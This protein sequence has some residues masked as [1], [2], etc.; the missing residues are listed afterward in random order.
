MISIF[1]RK[2]GDLLSL[3]IFP[4]IREESG[5]IFQLLAVHAACPN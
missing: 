5:E 4:G 3:W 2:I 1:Q